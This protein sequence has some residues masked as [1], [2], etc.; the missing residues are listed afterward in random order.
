VHVISMEKLA[1][2]IESSIIWHEKSISPDNI[3]ALYTYIV[4]SSFREGYKARLE[5]EARK[6]EPYKDSPWP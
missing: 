5:E 3:N 2:I 6:I 4:T 1:E